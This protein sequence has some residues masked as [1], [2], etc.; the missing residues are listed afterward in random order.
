MH[1]L[2]PIKKPVHG[3]FKP[4]YK[5][6]DIVELETVLLKA[7]M[8]IKAYAQPKRHKQAHAQKNRKRATHPKR[9]IL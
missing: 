4:P 2:K 5:L 1:S 7:L 8:P 6:L 3:R 9:R